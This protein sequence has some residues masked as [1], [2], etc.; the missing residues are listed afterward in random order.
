MRKM[1]SQAGLD[2][3]IILSWLD[4]HDAIT[5]GIGIGALSFLCLFIAWRLRK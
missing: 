1:Q 3:S 4:G 5:I 2:P